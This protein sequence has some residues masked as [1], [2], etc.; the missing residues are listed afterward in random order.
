MYPN[1]NRLER[2]LSL[3][4]DVFANEEEYMRTQLRLNG[5]KQNPS[6]AER[7]TALLIVATLLDGCKVSYNP[8]YWLFQALANSLNAYQQAIP[9]DTV[10]FLS[11]SL[12]RLG[13]DKEFRNTVLDKFG[14]K[15]MVADN[16]FESLD[17]IDADFLV[18][19]RQIYLGEQGPVLL[20]K[21]AEKFMALTERQR[22]IVQQFWAINDLH[23]MI[24]ASSAEQGSI[25]VKPDNLCD[26]PAV[27]DLLEEIAQTPGEIESR[28]NEFYRSQLQGHNII[29]SK[30]TSY[31][32]IIWM[33]YAFSPE[34]KEGGES[35]DNLKNTS[36]NELEVLGFQKACKN[37]LL[38]IQLNHF[39]YLPRLM[40]EVRK[41]GNEN[42]TMPKLVDQIGFIAALLTV[43]NSKIP[44]GSREA[45]SL[46]TLAN[47]ENL[48][49]LMALYNAEKL[50]S[51]DLTYDS[52]SGKIELTSAFA[53]ILSKEAMDKGI[54]TFFDQTS[55]SEPSD[56][57]AAPLY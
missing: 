37:M 34:R 1:D 3:G 5:I 9:Q 47:K 16:D 36:K 48:Q 44:K 45:V 46:I 13:S 18:H 21:S 4:L 28:M 51:A 49:P 23:N 40:N 17:R 20:V 42:D 26:F 30:D 8:N 14:M 43:I 11:Y 33:W 2:A 29:I 39:T 31:A 56:M 52:V 32:Q 22:A 6:L 57:L 24:L 53:A 7:D 55:I 15:E 25:T 38:C 27:V 41:L 10:M 19:L 50:D 12:S 54:Y 35:L